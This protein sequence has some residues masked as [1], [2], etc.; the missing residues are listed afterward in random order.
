[1][2]ENN[3]YIWICGENHG[4]TA[5][6]NSYYFWKHA[7][8]VE[9]EIDKYI[10]FQKNKDTLETYE[11]LSEYEKKF[12]IWK[13]S[14][15]HYKLYLNADLFFV[16]LS[17]KDIIPDKLLF[18]KI[19]WI[20]KKPVVY[21]GHGTTGMKKIYYTGDSYWN[22]MFRF[23][24]YNPEEI[25]YL[26]ENNNFRRHQLHFTEFPPR[27]GELIRKDLEYKDKN[28][29]LWFVTW[30]EYFGKNIETK[31]FVKQITDV[32]E[33]DELL[34]YLNKHELKLKLCVHQ[35]FDEETFEDIYN[36]SQNE[37]IDIVHS[38]NV[39][40]MDE[41][42]KSRLLITDY[43]SVAYDF[44][45]LNKPVLLYQSDLE[46]YN[47]TRDFFCRIDEL[48]EFN[49]KTPEI[50]INRII[51]EDYGINDF[52]RKTL[53]ENID[54]DY[55]KCNKHITQLYEYYANIQKNSVTIIGSN[56]YEENE[57]TNPIMS[58][59]E[60]LL[61]NKYLV[62]VIS[63]YHPKKQTF[64]PPLG[65][66]MQHL[67]WQ[68][69][70]SRIERLMCK[71]HSSSKNYSYLKYDPKKPFLH[72][73]CGYELK[74]LMKNIRS[75]TVISTRETTHLFLDNCESDKLKNKIYFIKAP[76]E[77]ETVA[78]ELINEIQN[79]NFEIVICTS[80]NDINAFEKEFNCK[81]NSSKIILN[82]YITKN[83][84]T[85]K[86]NDENAS[87]N[88]AKEKYYGISMMDFNK[89]SIE[90][91]NRIIEFGTYLKENNVENV[92][93]DVMGTGKYLNE[94]F[95]LIVENELMD[96]INYLSMARNVTEEIRKHDFIVDFYSNPSQNTHYL[97]GILNYKKV[98]C[99]KNPKSEEIFKDIPNTFIESYEW[100]YEQIVNLE[101]ITSEE[102]NV[103]Y[104]LIEKEFKEKNQGNIKSIF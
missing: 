30:R 75:R 9:D 12:V 76:G 4:N 52:I 68:T 21:L 73:S 104:D 81:I 96:Y 95:K 93:L 54:Y 82:D 72:P 102:L 90:D 8:N 26:I 18:K 17:Y 84:I 24:A 80:E 62:N 32:L 19:N 64:T 65:L 41:L 92:A 5:N 43:S 2:K 14:K 87:L 55:V 53:P 60:N 97:L 79:I 28:Q 33:S 99:L 56:F 61:E 45:F 44:T 42:A 38:K 47:K 48:N 98:F 94:F 11:N 63:L 7:V 10:V 70:P 16:T 20:I 36:H 35:F 103:N 50:L 15:K 78:P 51:C 101:K 59:A 34:D 23:L 58:L 71:L 29:L 86:I 1:M 25:D 27:Y 57:I 22:N 100:L 13:N 74:K 49:I 66:N 37:L 77:Y 40:V 31:L 39:N 88:M 46:I 85:P 67:Y 69:T 83:Q 3:N 91:M 89:Y 6:N